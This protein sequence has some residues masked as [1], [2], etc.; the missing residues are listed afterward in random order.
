LRE[1]KQA[2]QITGVFTNITNEDIEAASDV[3]VPKAEEVN[4]GEGGNAGEGGEGEHEKPGPGGSKGKEKP[5]PGDAA[6]K[7]KVRDGQERAIHKTFKWHGW[8]VA[9]ENPVGTT[10]SG[11]DHGGKPFSVRMFHD[12]GYLDGTVGADGED[13]DCFVGP[14]PNSDQVFVVHTLRAPDFKQYDEDKC[15]LDFS[16]ASEA[17]SAFGMNYNDSGY[18]GQ[19]ETFT[20]PEFLNRL[21]R[22]RV[23]PE[24]ITRDAKDAPIEAKVISPPRGE[25]GLFKDTGEYNEVQE[26]HLRETFA[27]MFQYADPWSGNPRTFDA[28]GNYLCGG[29]NK[30]DVPVACLAV[31][32]KISGDHGSCRHWENPDA[33]DSE[34]LFAAKI[35]QNMADYGVTPKD[36]FGCKRCEFHTKA[37]KAD[38]HGRDLFCKQG[39]F[40][41]FRNGCCALND[42]PGMISS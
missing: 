20:I 8:D 38:S 18:F 35:S 23:R 29:C 37:V 3:A 15:F 30:Y 9:I 13:V 33:G 6:A 27:S 41:V 22:T 2:S 25:D 40:R 26:A 16:S 32:G 39:A 28:A 17:R 24:A 14:N 5:G 42:T 1:L 10:R 11:T 36:G 34:L 4:T 12:Y 19:I 7:R 21:V 31:T